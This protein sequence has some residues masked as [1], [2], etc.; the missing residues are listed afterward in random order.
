MTFHY[1]LGTHTNLKQVLETQLDRPVE[2]ETKLTVQTSIFL[3]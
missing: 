2:N 3:V 1:A